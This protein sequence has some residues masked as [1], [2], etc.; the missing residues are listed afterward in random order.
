[1]AVG[2]RLR[3]TSGPDR[4]RTLE[5]A[6]LGETPAVI[7]RGGNP[8][9]DLVC[10]DAK[11][12]RRHAIIQTSPK[13]FVLVDCKSR[14]GTRLNGRRLDPEAPA[15]LKDGD[16]IG[17]ADET[18]IRFEFLRDE[19]STRIEKPIARPAPA[20]KPE[21]RRVPPARPAA[22]EPA[23]T[24]PKPPPVSPPP[25]PAPRAAPARAVPEAREHFGR[26]GIYET[27]D[28]SQTDR[29]DAAIDTQRGDR[30]AL[31]RYSSKVISRKVKSSVLES[32]T[33]GKRWQHP[34]IAEVVDAGEQAG[35]LYV[36]SRLVEGKS[37]S[38][39]Q[40]RFPR[41]FDI[42]LAAYIAREICAA[43]HYAQDQVS[44]FVHRNL[45]P[46][47]IMLGFKG[48]V[49]L[50][51]VG[52]VPVRVAADSTQVLNRMEARHLSPEHL[53]GRG[54]DAR[55]DIFSV[56]VILYELLAQEPIDPRK[57][58]VLADVD[59]I[60]PEVPPA[61]AKAT[62]RAIALRPTE[63]FRSAQE[64]EEELV[65]VLRQMAPGYG[66]EAAQWM[67]KRFTAP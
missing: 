45:N 15:P 6:K 52:F 37:L 33:R 57:K 63:R 28:E 32:A 17:C 51:N 44:G 50:I 7:G 22:P 29:V 23:A 25:P 67:A 8:Q 64:M 38:E 65:E 27:L 5:V 14:N 58:A 11:I 47:T 43:L 10:T 34:N 36:A 4:G 40:T 1:M 26:Y 30:V 61:L 53:A 13:G 46:R 2:F 21:E 20:P 9:H 3:V 55:S 35:T 54:I 42:P 39:L 31:K 16:E 66:P 12:S 19:D 18:V 60:R 48:D 41:E 49:V 62:M 24:R 59:T 56:G